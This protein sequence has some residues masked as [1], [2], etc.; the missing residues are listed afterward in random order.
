MLAIAH[1]IFQG[2]AAIR[3]H[4]RRSGRQDHARAGSGQDSC[5]G[6][7]EG[8][9]RQVRSPRT[10]PPNL[11]ITV[12]L[13]SRRDSAG[14]TWART[15]SRPPH[16]GGRWD[17]PFPVEHQAGPLPPGFPHDH[18]ESQSLPA[19]VSLWR[20]EVADRVALSF[21]ILSYPRKH[22]LPFVCAATVRPEGPCPTNAVPRAGF[23]APIKRRV[24]ANR[25]RPRRAIGPP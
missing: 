1:G 9:N 8:G 20:D 14:A 7:R 13:V 6:R 11:Q 21:C 3:I 15:T 10:D 25:A 2:Q 16:R 12:L 17:Q 22:S 18:W 23:P 5:R 24:N 4:P 19:A